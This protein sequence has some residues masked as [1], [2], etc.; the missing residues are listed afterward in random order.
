MT[1]S[2][3]ALLAFGSHPATEPVQCV[4]LDHSDLLTSAN[5]DFVSI[6]D[7]TFENPPHPACRPPSPPRPG[8]EKGSSQGRRATH[9]WL[10]PPAEAVWAAL[11]LNRISLFSTPCIFKTNNP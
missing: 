1:G 5:R 7:G 9:R 8:G 6:V 2:F 3:R 10:T 4:N 11:G